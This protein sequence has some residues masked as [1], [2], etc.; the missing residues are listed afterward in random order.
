MAV[1]GADTPQIVAGLQM[2]HELW[3]SLLD[4][5]IATWLLER[6]LSLA[7]LAPVALVLG[8]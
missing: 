8:M 3:A 4:V 6:K 5:A 7:C 1:L 2:I